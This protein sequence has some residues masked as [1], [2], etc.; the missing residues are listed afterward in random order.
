V[1][2]AKNLWVI[3]IPCILYLGSIGTHS[4][5]AQANSSLSVF[6]VA[7]GILMLTYQGVG[8][9]VGSPIYPTYGIPYLSISVSLNLLLT[10]MIVVRLVLH[11]RDIRATMGTPGGFGG[12][13]K[14]IATMM[15]ESSAAYTISSLL[16][17]GPMAANS[18]AVNIFYPVLAET[19]VRA[20][21]RP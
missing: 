15:I 1:I 12:L 18:L 16:V 6:N 17:L 11:S 4:N 21:P 14:T 19:Q 8:F 9:A 10:T 2:Y 3:V 5:F 13:Y 20:H 7:M